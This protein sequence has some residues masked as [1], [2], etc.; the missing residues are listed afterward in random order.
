MKQEFLVKGLHCKSCEILIE[1]KLSDKKGIKKAE[2]VLSENKLKIES[3]KKISVEKLNK[4]FEESDYV[5]DTKPSV[6]N[7]ATSPLKRAILNDNWW[8]L[9]V[10]IIAGLFVAEAVFR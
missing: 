4:W 3:D 5:F 7:K 6:A 8:W 1:E 2:V 10:V 9:G